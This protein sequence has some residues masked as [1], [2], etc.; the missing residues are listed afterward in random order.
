GIRTQADLID[1]YA[2]E[3]LISTQLQQ[4]AGSVVAEMASRRRLSIRKVDIQNPTLDELIK[5]GILVESGHS[6]DLVS[7]PHHL[8]FDYIAGRYHLAWHDPDTLLEQLDGDTSM[9][10]LLAPALRFTIERMWRNDNVERPTTWKLVTGIYS[11]NRVEPVLSNVAMRVVVEYIDNERDV[12]ALMERV[13][14]SPTDFALTQLLGRFAMFASMDMDSKDP[15]T[16]GRAIAS[17]RLAETL[18]HSGERLLLEPARVLLRPLFDHGDL[19]ESALLE[20]FGKASRAM[21]EQAWA[22]SP[23]PPATI[24][25]AIRF[26]GRSFASDPP[27]SRT[28]LQRILRDPHFSQYADREAAWLAEQIVPITRADPEFAVEI[29]AALFGQTITDDASSWLGAQPSRI[30]PLS[31]NRRQDYEHCRWQLGR[32]M[33]NVLEIAPGHGTRALIDALIGKVATQGYGGGLEPERI[34]LGSTKLELRGY[35][36]ELNA[37]DDAEEDGRPRDDDL[38]QQY[39]LFLRNCDSETFLESVAEAS[40]DYAT[41]SVWARI[42]GV[43]TERIAEV[44]DLLWP[45]LEHPGLLENPGTLRDAVRFVRAAWPSRS[46]EA[47]KRFETMALDETSYRDQYG[48]RRWKHVLGRILSEVREE[49]L[50][51]EETRALRRQLDAEGLL[52]ENDPIHNFTTREIAHDDFLRDELRRAGVNLETGALRGL[53][54]ASES[55]GALIER[56]P[57]DSPAPDLAALWNRAAELIVQ[58]DEIQDIPKELARLAWGHIATGIERLVSSP[59]YTPGSHGMPDLHEMLALLE[60]LS[61]SQFPEPRTSPNKHVAWTNCAVRVHA[62]EA[63]VSLAQHFAAVHPAIVDQIEQ[64]LADPDPA[65]RFQASRNLHVICM[66]APDRMWEMAESIASHEPASE[67][68]ASYLSDSLRRFSHSAPDRCETILSLVKGRLDGDFAS[69]IEGSTLV[70]EALA[71]W[72]AHLFVGQGRKLA[73]FWLREWAVDPERYHDLLSP[74][75]SSLRNRLFDRYAIQASAK[76]LSVCERAQDGLKIILSEAVG[77]SSETYSVI[78]SDAPQR[79]RELA[80]ERYGS[81]ERVIN[82][83]ITQLYFGSGAHAEDRE[84]NIGLPDSGAKGRFLTDYSEILSLIANSHEPATFHRLV[85]LYEF[86]IPGNPMQVFDAIHTILTG[87]GKEEGY[88]YESLGNNAIIR[89]IQRYMADYKS[90]FENPDRRSRLVS[91]LQLFSDVGWPSALELLYELPDH[92]R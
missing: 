21:L 73:S 83:A 9:A 70:Q 74:F 52:I 63:W 62:A 66:A 84:G 27:A 75:I 16:L 45:L 30:L 39:V 6:R 72:A 81:A 35:E 58:I 82:H 41:A 80:W 77:V 49:T 29:Y 78:T 2:D 14:T 61:S 13:A 76:A 15:I 91:I 18:A 24:P 46:K 64:I 26:V 50:E 10:L 48:L 36:I 88:Q 7:F 8:L 65:V 56:T 69:G 71:G 55:L 19:E 32:A 22:A 38:L 31:S 85:E 42:L 25:N 57:S 1:A 59:N 17:A 87:P 67:V 23:R 4:A 12:A 60:R 34:D 37:W 5:T 43:G 54:D 89:I 44:E 92:M 47:R 68:V 40:R 20:V 90:I 53:V 28:L 33:R 51:L 11:A 3:R 86:L 79:D